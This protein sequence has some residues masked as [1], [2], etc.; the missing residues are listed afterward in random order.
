MTVKRLYEVHKDFE[1]VYH[2]NSGEKFEI[3]DPDKEWD[4]AKWYFK[5]DI[6]DYVIRLMKWDYEVQDYKVQDVPMGTPG[7]HLKFEHLLGRRIS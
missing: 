2:F 7:L 1:P 5:E 4:C 6:M 3:N